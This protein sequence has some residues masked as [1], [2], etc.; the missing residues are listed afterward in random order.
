MCFRNRATRA[1]QPFNSDPISL[2]MTHASSVIARDFS[3]ASCMVWACMA[4]GLLACSGP[5]P[6]QQLAAAE[7]AAVEAAHDS[8]KLTHATNL[9]EGV[10]SAQQDTPN[11]SRALKSLAVLLQQRGD[12]EGAIAGYQRLLDLYPGSAEADEAQFMIAFIYEEHLGDFEAARKAYQAVIDN[13]P[14]TELAA[15]A[16]R[17]LPN[18]GRAPEEWVNFQDDPAAP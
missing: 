5:S 7:A 4:V 11:A 6:E 12:L 9:L 8:T 16:Q 15:N 17:L 2:P 1:P 14:G 18:V 13:H 10:I 3:A